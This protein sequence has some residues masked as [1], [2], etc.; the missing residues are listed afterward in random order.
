CKMPKASMEVEYVQYKKNNYESIRE[1]QRLVGPTWTAINGQHGFRYLGSKVLVYENEYIVKFPDGSID[2]FKEWNFFDY[3]TP[4]AKK[5]PVIKEP[6]VQV[7]LDLPLGHNL[8]DP[9]QI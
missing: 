7:N 4:I 6:T 9:Y 1:C 2:V 8:K 5:V 3:F